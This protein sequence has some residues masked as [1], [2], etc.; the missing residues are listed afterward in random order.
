MMK[1]MFILV[2]AFLLVA[3][4]GAKANAIPL[5]DLFDGSTLQ[6]DDK[7]FSDWTLIIELVSDPSQDP[8][9]NLIEVEPLEDPMNPGIRFATNDQL[10][11]T[12]INFIDIEFSFRVTSLDP[13]YLIKD[14]SLDLTDYFFDGI[15]GS[16]IIREGVYDEAG[17]MIAFKRVYADNLYQDFILS[18][19]AEFEPQSSIYIEKN[20]VLYSEFDGET[21]W[22]NEFEQRFSQ[23]AVFEPATILLLGS[24]LV[25]IGVLRRRNKL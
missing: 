23:V 20:I 19:S 3:G 15:G 2:F 16:I 4:L 18:H 24:G 21:L 1:R 17:N 5:Q 6:V 13:G 8:D 11:A 25:G 10:K 9:Y 14:N 7:L 22:V 12:D